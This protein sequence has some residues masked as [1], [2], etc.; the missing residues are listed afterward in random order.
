MSTKIV[1]TNI[2]DIEEI[3]IEEMSIT[4]TQEPDCTDSGDD[5]KL[6]ITA[7][8][9]DANLDKKPE[10]YFYRLSTPEGRPFAI[11]GKEELL[12][13]FDDFERRFKM[14]VE[15]RDEEQE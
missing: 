13:I 3:G 1:Y 9:G 15:N 10:H 12:T 6:T 7:R 4:Y 5:Q 2:P 8:C 14:K 11:N